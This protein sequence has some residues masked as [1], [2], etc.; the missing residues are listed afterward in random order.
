MS[1]ARANL[2]FIMTIILTY[3]IIYI[4]CENLNRCQLIKNT[5][6]KRPWHDYCNNRCLQELKYEM[7]N[8]NCHNEP[9]IPHGAFGMSL[10]HEDTTWGCY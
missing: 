5:F 4:D 9:T 2:S 3:F 10:C 1:R 6:D 7:R 8:R